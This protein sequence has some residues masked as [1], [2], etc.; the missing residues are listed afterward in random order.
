V[1]HW[2]LSLFMQTFLQHRY[3][4]H[5]AFSMNK[6]WERFFYLL[7]YI[8]QG[9][10]YISPRVYGI[11]H[12]MHHAY[13]DTDKDPHSPKFDTTIIKMMWH[14]RRVS[15]GIYNNTFEVEPRFCK[16]VPDWPLLDK[17]ANSWA[18]RIA[19]IAVYVFIYVM[20]APSAWWFILLPIHILMVPIHG[21]IINWFA[22][23]YGS[24]NFQMK[25]TS[26]NL[27]KLDIFMMGEGYHNN[28][29]KNPSSVNF[30][31]RWY[32][33]DPAYPIIRFLNWVKIIRVHKVAA[34]PVL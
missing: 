16:N 4:A 20:F 9:S 24:V 1:G 12:R 2:Y 3:A 28:H 32:E 14:T 27:F 19:W 18:S 33:F 23:K 5:A 25:N 30:G 6:F 17:I 7:T 26:T 11:M 22:H 34:I 21:M 15:A 13:T 29:H 10:S 8:T 31:F